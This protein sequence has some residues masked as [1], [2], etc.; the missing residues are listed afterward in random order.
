MVTEGVIAFAA[1]GVL[2]WMIFWMAR[3]ARAI[4][5][6]L[7]AKVD[8][9]VAAGSSIALG[10]VAF[11]AVAREGLE[12]ALFLISTTVGE[13]AGA[14]QLLGGILGT[15]AAV[16]IGYLVYQG[17]NRLNLRLFFRIT[18]VMI[19]LFAAGLVAK[20][21]H[22]FEEVGLLPSLIDHVW[23]LSFADPATSLFWQFMKSLFGWRPDPS[24]L[25]VLGYLAYLVPIGWSFLK[26]TTPPT[27]VA[28]PVA[29][30]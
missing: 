3:Q 20:G 22:E 9:A 15:L 10:M 7:Q 28:Q 6:Q 5:G 2:T 16:V 1:A 26:A 30:G 25:M 13:G 29:V 17:G 4:R 23:T 19:I 14:G 11:T 8:V 27:T 21:V 18:G 24:L 12:S